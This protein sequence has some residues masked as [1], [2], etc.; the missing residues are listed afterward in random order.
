MYGLSQPYLSDTL[1]W[2]TSRHFQ[3][4][5]CWTSLCLQTCS[6]QPW[7]MIKACGEE[8]GT[9][10]RERERIEKRGRRRRKWGQIE[11][12]AFSLWHVSWWKDHFSPFL[13]IVFF[14][15]CSLPL[16]VPLITHSDVCPGTAGMSEMGITTEAV[17]V[18]CLDTS[19]FTQKTW[20]QQCHTASAVSCLLVFSRWNKRLNN[21]QV[22][23]LQSELT[24]FLQQTTMPLI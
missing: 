10:D 14:I 6:P 21:S 5:T 12:G 11:K 18:P 2:F 24:R 9:T 15:P 16:S 7:N 13:G 4:R 17:W 3:W 8:E 22:Y 1:V 23:P 19:L 20:S